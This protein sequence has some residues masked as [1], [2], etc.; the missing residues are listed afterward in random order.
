MNDS[1]LTPVRLTF[2]CCSGQ[3]VP[4]VNLYPDLANVESRAFARQVSY[5]F[6]YSSTHEDGN[7]F[8]V[9]PRLMF[10]RV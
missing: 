5:L 1:I 6:S 4:L 2:P 7:F 8:P 10:Q 3:W 9:V